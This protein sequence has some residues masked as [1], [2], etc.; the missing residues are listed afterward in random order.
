M[1][2]VMML[3]WAR[4]SKFVTSLPLLMGLTALSACGGYPQHPLEKDLGVDGS[5][6]SQ[7]NNLA[8]NPTG[9]RLAFDGYIIGI[10][11]IEKVRETNKGPEEPYPQIIEASEIDPGCPWEWPAIGDLG[12]EQ[13]RECHYQRRVLKQDKTMAVT[14]IIAHEPTEDATRYLYNVYATSDRLDKCEDEAKNSDLDAPLAE[15]C[16]LKGLVK[17]VEESP[18]TGAGYF[19]DGIDALRETLKADLHAKIASKSRDDRYTH[20]VLAAAGWDNDQ[21][22]SVAHYNAVLS[23]IQQAAEDQGDPF[24]PLFVGLTWPSVWGN[25]DWIFGLRYQLL[26]L[27][28]YGNK[29]DDADEI[30]YTIFNLLLNEVVADIKAEHRDLPVVVFGHSFGARLTSRGVFSAD[31]LSSKTDR[32]QSTV[33]V[34]IGLQP[35]FSVRRF[36][37]GEGREGAP[38]RP[39]F[40]PGVPVVLSTSMHDSANPLARYLTFARH[41]GGEPGLEIMKAFPL[42]GDPAEREEGR[43]EDDYRFVVLEE[44]EADGRIDKACPAWR[45]TFEQ[46]PKAVFVV[47]AKT[48]VRSHGDVVDLPAGR[49]IW[50][51]IT[52]FTGAA[53]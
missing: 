7:Y 43:S 25:D 10:E 19:M 6:T 39:D 26:K 1:A 29:A 5:I 53:S 40:A 36:L 37:I 52:C 18:A 32:E 34:F 47:D 44:A 49:M 17:N 28:G 12:E 11:K 15:Y 4:P 38:Y 45:E 22:V 16:H 3:D 51:S 33:D 23:N 9:A 48:F 24:R 20:V 13:G 35:A 30:G 31:R 8:L 21:E 46:D 2:I 50:D 42:N 14:H 27:I 41:V